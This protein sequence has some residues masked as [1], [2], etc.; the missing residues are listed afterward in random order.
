L[1]F[2]VWSLGFVNPVHVLVNVPVNEN[3]GVV[4]VHVHGFERINWKNLQGVSGFGF[5]INALV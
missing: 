1:V 3:F 5:R 4:N 2:W